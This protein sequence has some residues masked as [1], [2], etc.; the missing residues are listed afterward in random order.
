MIRQWFQGFSSDPLRLVFS[1]Y[2]TWFYSQC[3]MNPTFNHTESNVPTQV[4]SLWNYKMKTKVVFV[5]SHAHAPWWK[6]LV[7]Q[8]TDSRGGATL[9]GAQP[10]GPSVSAALSTSPIDCNPVKLLQSYVVASGSIN[11]CSLNWFSFLGL[12]WWILQWCFKEGRRALAGLA[13]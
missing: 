11:L 3:Q 4:L 10:W 1:S 6:C 5:V 12:W 13:Q 7:L 9:L 2:C 8:K